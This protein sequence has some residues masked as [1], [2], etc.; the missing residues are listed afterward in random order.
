MGLQEIPEELLD[1]IIDLLDGLAPSLT[2]DVQLPHRHLIETAETPLKCLSQTS[3]QLRRLTFDR[4]FAHLRFN[5]SVFA[6]T[7]LPDDSYSGVSSELDTIP[8]EFDPSALLDQTLAGF[9]SFTSALE[10]S[11]VK[12]LLIYS[13]FE[14]EREDRWHGATL[15]K[16]FWQR[17]L[18]APR[19]AIS[20]T[21]IAPPQALSR[22]TQVRVHV[23]DIWAFDMPYQ[24]LRL[25][26][27]GWQTLRKHG[28]GPLDLTAS[29]SHLAYDEGSSLNLYG[30]YHYQDK[31]PPSMLHIASRS[32]RFAGSNLRVLTYTA[33][34]P[35][36]DS[37]KE[38]LVFLQTCECLEE[39]NLTLAPTAESPLLSDDSRV[40]RG[41]TSF[42]DCWNELDR[43]YFADNLSVT[44]HMTTIAN[45]K[46]PLRRPSL[47]V[48]CFHDCR[49]PSIESEFEEH[50][51]RSPGWHGLDEWKRTSR[52]CYEIV[53]EPLIE[54]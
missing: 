12:T 6:D 31:L 47:K 44:R 38:F 11:T 51:G 48:V 43:C 4:L 40:G 49:I 53:E 25:D 45:T 1:T 19:A 7:L 17:L 46:V 10:P 34:F 18:S 42:R 39:L 52:G 24:R 20:M 27:P 13:L 37:F 15:F 54:D 41:S 26:S 5:A 35:H 36:Y 8:T 28:E 33:V 21:I 9:E 50:W 22:L 16:A 2:P 32:M 30:H 29:W 14:T 23:R 3:K